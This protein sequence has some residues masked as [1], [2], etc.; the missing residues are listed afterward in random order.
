LA[1]DVGQPVGVDAEA[2][3]HGAQI[4]TGLGCAAEV[5]PTLAKIRKFG[6]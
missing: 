3:D 1:Y 2:L 6:R 4:L 5:A